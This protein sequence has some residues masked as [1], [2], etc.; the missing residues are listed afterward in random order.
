MVEFF[1]SA[2]ERISRRV[3]L[4][5]R[6]P[7]R[8]GGAVLYVSPDSALR[9]WRPGLESADPSLLDAACELDDQVAALGVG[10]LEWELPLRETLAEALRCMVVVASSQKAFDRV[11]VRSLQERLRQAGEGAGMRAGAH[12]GHR[13]L[14]RWWSGSMEGWQ[15]R[16]H[17][18]RRMGRMRQE[19]VESRSS[20]ATP[21]SRD[22]FHE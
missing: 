8:V 20:S 2:L 5:K 21:R 13:C 9:F 6:L 4:R 10:V 18:R 1:R 7:R 22:D 17:C 15:G 3:V 19:R 16:A 12:P 11:R 14:Q